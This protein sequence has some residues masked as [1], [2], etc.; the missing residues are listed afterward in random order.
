MSRFS[1]IGVMALITSAIAC[2]AE[3]APAAAGRV[4]EA[5][6]NGD[7]P[8]LSR[9]LK[10]G[11]VNT[12]DERGITPLMYA[13]A[14]GNAAEMT[15][16]LEAGADVNRRNAFGATALIYA[17]GDPVKSRMLIDR[18]AD[19]NAISRQGR[20]PLISA[21]QHD[22]NSGLVRVLLEKGQIHGPRAGLRCSWPLWPAIPKRCGCS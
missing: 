3:N 10:T 1:Q 11:I 6:R 15:A 2:A 16:L 17:N 4:Y 14:I 12:P 19:V 22:G 5:I 13:A 7:L 9:L 20:T 18:G 8:L 21:A